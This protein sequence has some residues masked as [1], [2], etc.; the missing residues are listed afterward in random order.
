LTNDL[1]AIRAQIGDLKTFQAN[2]A[3][4]NAEVATLQAGY[5]RLAKWYADQGQKQID[6]LRE[7]SSSVQELKQWQTTTQ[8]TIAANQAAVAKMGT[9]VGPA[10]PPGAAGT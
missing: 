3:K 7:M 4:V 1:E 2:Q 6:Q 5:D 9:V 8:S 10:G